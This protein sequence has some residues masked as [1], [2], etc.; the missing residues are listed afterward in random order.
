MR[1]AAIYDIHGNLPALEAM[2][3]EIRRV[4]VDQIVVG[5]DVVPGPMPRESLATL[6]EL[7][8]PEAARKAGPPQGLMFSPFSRRAIW[9][10]RFCFWGPSGAIFK[11]TLACSR[12]FSKL[13]S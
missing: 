1:V 12:A 3:D 7:P 5:G 10:S 2:L 8:M 9:A 11:E 4:D 6:L 13:P